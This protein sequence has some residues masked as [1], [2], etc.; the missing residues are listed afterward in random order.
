VKKIVI[1]GG[2]AGGVVVSTRLCK[3]LKDVEI[4]LIDKNPNHEFRPSYLWVVTGIREPEDVSRPLKLLENKGIKVLNKEVLSID[5][6]NRNIKLKDYVIDYDY[7]VISLGTELK[8]EYLKGSE[9]SYHCWELKDSLKLREAISK[10]KGG[11][12]VIG[13]ASYPYRCPPA[14]FELA[15]MLRYISEQR[16]ISKD[17]SITVIHPT[18]NEPMEP[19]GP[20]MQ[21]M[22]KQ[23]LE[24]YNI[25]FIGKWQVDYID[26]SKKKVFSKNGDNLD[27]DLAIIIPPHQ[28]SSALLN[29]EGL[30]DNKNGYMSVNKKNL[31]HPNYD[32]VFGIGD[33]IAPSLGI[34]MA[35]VFAHFEGDYVATQIIDEIKGV[36]MAMDYN[37][38]GI[39]VMDMGFLGAA[40]FCDF[41]KVIDRGGFKIFKPF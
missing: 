12:V 35:G 31:R 38:V 23:F 4:T 25:E 7:L 37:K 41:S 16:A 10:F 27:Y 29:S 11:K 19:F 6:A 14:P 1:L 18:W 13:P 32:D 36:Y 2:G 33:I 28:P 9:N 17:T 15:L 40:V 3:K 20:F 8:P 5:L 26:N 39:C 30:I 34:G 21:A 22:F 24:Q